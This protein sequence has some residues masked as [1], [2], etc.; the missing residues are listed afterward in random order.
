MTTP[1]QYSPEGEADR[2][3]GCEFEELGEVGEPV[4]VGR[5]H[6]GFS[7]VL[8]GAHVS[9]RY[10][11]IVARRPITSASDSGVV[12]K[13]LGIPALGWITYCRSGCRV[14]QPVSGA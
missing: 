9:E 6:L 13:L 12:P 11:L 10:S 8:R 5:R 2:D 4:A 3:D 1:C 7:R 14:S